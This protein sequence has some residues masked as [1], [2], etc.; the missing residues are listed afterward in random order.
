M[1]DKIFEADS[2]F[3]V[4]WGTAAKVQ[5]SFLLALKKISF[6]EEDWAL[7]YNSMNF[8]DFPDIS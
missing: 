5:G 8:L 1:I 4:K 2:S 6:W 7:S 3:H